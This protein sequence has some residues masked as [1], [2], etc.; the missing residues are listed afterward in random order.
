LIFL[1]LIVFDRLHLRISAMLVD[2]NRTLIEV[3]CRYA[4]RSTVE[5]PVT[6]AE[7]MAQWSQPLQ[8]LAG[9][10]WKEAHKA[11]RRI[12]PKT[13]SLLLR[14]LAC[15]GARSMNIE[16]Q[17]PNNSV[18]RWFSM[19][20]HVVIFQ[21]MEEDDRWEIYTSMSSGNKVLLEDAC[22]ALTSLAAIGL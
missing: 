1:K 16:I 4:M 6:E 7:F 17:G 21:T 11:D 14:H 22:S 9:Q 15:I 5:E 13:Q 3:A 8:E 12:S 2:S 20:G 18:L 10:V 19:R